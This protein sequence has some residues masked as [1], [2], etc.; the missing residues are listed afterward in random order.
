[1]SL[2]KNC[3]CNEDCNSSK[4]FTTQNTK[5]LSVEFSGVIFKNPV[6]TASGTFGYGREFS[7]FI[8][9]NELGG[10]T[11]KGVSNEEWNGN[12]PHRIAEVYGGMLNSIGLQ[13]PGVDYFI[14]E[15]IPFLKKYKTNII[16]NVCGRSV[17][18]YVDVIEKLNTKAVHMY[19]LNISCPNVKEGGIAF[20]TSVSQVE[21][22]VS[23][24]KK[25]AKKPLII[26][27]SPNVTSITEIAK[28]AEYAGA[29]G[30][31]LINTLLGMSIDIRRKK[32]V[33]GNIMGGLSG[34]AIKPVALRMVYEVSKAVN[35]PIIGMGGII[36]YEDALE[37]IMAGASLIAVG[38]A[39]FINPYA[40][41]DIINGLE[42]YMNNSKVSN[43]NEI[44]GII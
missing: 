40:T 19:E 6:I 15:E 17:Q 7:N 12:P 23:E 34:P 5:D 8:D 2:D 36:N 30:L 10:I 38:T 24:T 29:D 43:L 39:N 27:L 41:V 3:Q 35:I 32:P 28:A 14:K 18:D 9:L 25:A 4:M 37:F 13:N 33:L 21:K 22:I 11:V 1:M 20:G 16:V 31:S 44:R 42:K 26:K